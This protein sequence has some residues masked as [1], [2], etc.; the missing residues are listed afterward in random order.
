MGEPN[1]SGTGGEYAGQF[2]G[3]QALWNDLGGSTAYAADMSSVYNVMGYVRETNL[4]DSPLTIDAGGGAVSFGADVGTSKAL[5]NLTLSNVGVFSANGSVNLGGNLGLSAQSGINP[6]IGQSAAWVIGGTSSFNVGTGN[7]TLDRSDNDFTGAVSITSAADVSL[8]DTT[9][10]E[11]GSV[12]LSGAFTAESSEL[13]LTGDLTSSGTGDIFIKSNSAT[14]GSIV[15]NGDVFKTGGDRSTLT[16]QADGR[17]NINGD[18]TATVTSLDT[19]LWSDFH[20]TGSGG[21]SNFG[22]VTTNGGHVWAGGSASDGGSST[23]N[24][25]TVGD[26]ASEGADGFNYNALDLYGSLSTGGGDVMLRAGDGYNSGIDG[27][28]I[29]GA[30]TINSVTGDITILANDVDG[31]TIE[32]TSTGALTFAPHDNAFTEIGTSINWAGATATGTFTGTGD[33]GWLIINNVTALGGLTIGKEGMTSSIDIDSAIE[34]AGPINLLGND[35]TINASLDTTGGGAA[36]DILLKAKDQVVV[37]ANQSITT[38]D[39]D[40]TFWSDSDANGH[41]NIR[42]HDGVTLNTA[43]GST[44][45][46]SGGGSIVIGGGLDSNSDDRPDGFATSATD[47]GV[48]FGTST[49]NIT[50]IHS[51]GGDV[52]IKGQST[53]TAAAQV[54]GFVSTGSLTVNSGGGSIAITGETLSI[55]NGLQFGFQ[56]GS[57][58]GA[59]LSSSASSGTAISISGKT[60][61]SSSNGVSIGGGDSNLIEATGGGDIIISA[62]GAGN[63]SGIALNDVDIL[64]SSG[65]IQLDAGTGRIALTDTTLG[66]KAGSSVTA[67]SSDVVFTSDRIKFNTGTAVATTGSLTVQPFSTSFGTTLDWQP[68]N[69]GTTLGSLTIGKVGNTTAIEID[70]DITTIGA[71]HFYG[72]TLLSSN[73]DLNTTNSAVNFYGTVDS[74]STVR[75]LS[76]DTG[77]AATTFEST[78][79]GTEAL[80]NLN[81]T[82]LSNVNAD[83]TTTVEQSY[84]GELTIGGSGVRTLNAGTLTTN[85]IVASSNDFVLKADNFAIGGDVTGTGNATLN[86]S[87]VGAD[88]GVGTATDTVEVDNA[89]LLAFQDGFASITVGETD[90]GSLSVSG[91]TTMNDD[92]TLRAGA[93]EDLS[94]SGA[95]T[96]VGNN[97]LTL[98][99]GNDIFVNDDIDVLGSGAALNLFY[100]GTDGTAEATSGTDFYIDVSAKRQIT[101]ADTAAAL[102]IGNEAF[103]LVDSVAS[104][105][106]MSSSGNYALADD[107][108]L[109]GTTYT[110]AFY[111]DTFAGKLDGLGHAANGLKVTAG[112]GGNYGLFDQLSAASVRHFGVTNIDLLGQSSAAGAADDLRIGG[113]VGNVSGSG[114]TRLDG[115]WSSGVIATKQ[116]SVQ[117]VFYA[118]GLVGGH[119]SGTLEVTRSFSTANVSSEGSNS[120]KMS[121]GGLLGDSGSFNGISAIG[122]SASHLLIDR[123]Y[124]TGSI[125]EG[126]YDGY[127][128]SGGLVGVVFG[129]S[130]TLTDSFSRSNVVGGV[131][132][133][134]IAGFSSGTTTKNYDR[135]YTTLDRFGNN[136]TPRNSYTIDTLDAATS[137]GTVLPSTWSSSIWTTGKFPTLNSVQTPATLLYVKIIFGTGVYGNSVAPTY[138][139][140]D[141]SDAEVNFGNGAYSDLDGVTGT[142]RY[143]VGSDSSAGT[144]DRVSYLSG[145]GLTGD[146][147]DLYALNPHTTAGSY[148]ITPRPLTVTLSNSGVTKIYD[149]TTVAPSGFTPAFSLGNL[150]SGDAAAAINYVSAL[151]NDADVADASKLTVGGLS[152][153]SITGSNGSLVTDYS[154]SSSVDVAASITP[155]PIVVSG[156]LGEDKIYDGTTTASIDISSMSLSGIISGDD[157]SVTSITALFGNKNVGTDK[158]VTLSA[159]VFGGTDSGNYSI[160]PQSSATADINVKSITVQGITTADKVYDGTI[161]AVDDVSGLTFNGIVSGDNLT[162]ADTTGVFSSRNVDSDKTVILSDTSYGG[163]DVG[164]YNITDQATSVADVTKKSIT[165]SGVTAA[166]KVY[167]GSASAVVDLSGVTFDGIV[168]GDNL[169][170]ADTTG[171]FDKKNGGADKAV[172]LSGTNYSGSDVGNYSF[173]DQSLTTADVTQKSITV[174]GIAA[175]NKVYD[176]GTTTFVDLS[177]ITFAGIVS[178]DDLTATDGL[179]TFDNK[180]VGANKAITLSGTNYGGTDVGNYL[181]NDQTASTASITP[182]QV[183]VSGL[184]AEDRSY[185]GN[186]TSTIGHDGLNVAGLVVGDDVTTSGTTGSIVDKNVGTGK[187]VNLTGT[188]YGG[189]D[190]ANYNFLDQLVAFAEISRLSS[191]TWVGGPT[192][193][194][195]D[196]ANWAG[197]AVPDLANVADV[198]IPDGVTPVFDDSVSGPV[199]IESLTGGSLQLDAGDLHVNQDAALDQFTQNGGTMGVEGNFEVADF[200]QNAGSL[201]V[202]GELDVTNSFSQSETATTDVEGDVQ[203]TQTT[204]DLVI[205]NLSGDNVDLNSPS[206]GIELGN[207]ETAGTLNATAGDGSITQTPGSQITV[208]GETTLD[209]TEDIL[210]AEAGNDFDGPVNASGENVEITDGNGG[211]VLGQIT[212]TGSFTG[213]STGGP[214]TQTED[215]SL[216]IAGT[217]T[218]TASENGSPSDIILDGDS[219]DFGGTVNADGGSIQLVD[220]SGGLELGTVKASG[221]LNVVSTDGPLTQTESGSIDVEGSSSFGAFVDG[222]PDQVILDN[223]DNRFGDSVDVVGGAIQIQGQ[224]QS[225]GAINFGTVSSPALKSQHQGATADTTLDTNTRYIDETQDNLTIQNVVQRLGITWIRRLVDWYSGEPEVAD[226]VRQQDLVINN[227]DVF[228]RKSPGSELTRLKER[229]LQ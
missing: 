85:D 131:S 201:E 150:I 105:R 216:A 66:Q 200:E 149:N 103:T 215:S 62:T 118:G 204:G 124:A 205:N 188:V 222:E 97:A 68:I 64:A 9:S 145:L 20:D 37:A 104:L 206:G 55:T 120:S 30:Q 141:R 164:N 162:A 212:A 93:G 67:S 40:I 218:L 142:G 159:P 136:H 225:G 197:G 65:D 91:L 50:T 98:A 140:V 168:S 135:L 183:T 160:T 80:R 33:A 89:T 84:G 2:F 1:G 49:A 185:N 31:G 176:G 134:G 83:V 224:S 139:I 126:T 16:V 187:Q 189:A 198:V 186:Q 193:D 32:V 100:G 151:F 167:D 90:S 174:S 113:I 108:S 226:L 166:D 46:A 128:G 94:V 42:I 129:T 196:P 180:N 63:N 79:G 92:F 199:E 86:S 163:T 43:D 14:D 229:D 143:T 27:I 148:T 95:I 109:A 81:V 112:T 82:G 178:G 211:L 170:A 69:I 221:D 132:S 78:V 115:V 121:V 223:P 39:A 13:T 202:L 114:T 228:I 102:K 146:D 8:K 169:T 122:G 116:G 130:A 73:I 88:L 77:T 21:V 152:I 173:T 19:V 44:S 155:K 15:I 74:S 179:G 203:I 45:Q 99:A 7:I 137:N 147:A 5:G 192:G 165:I 184:A 59:R 26:G 10:L 29:N 72:P 138:Q 101:F 28:G 54:R 181:I 11:L 217:T 111:N 194:W 23:W 153:A 123:S 61:N 53:R 12:T 76:I 18:I 56:A 87:T 209:A 190:A 171:E 154:I 25:L 71:Q 213:T 51:G 158:V 119:D 214:I 177:G 17:V 34:I 36:A 24:G 47:D 6:T 220:S 96:W 219:N 117:D 38:D 110:E 52:V 107:L 191:V 133:G 144:Y 125:V 106:G 35:V 175:S 4:A 60:A 161:S 41:G 70:D 208:G 195:S 157:V 207:V 57:G 75:N 58:S 48:E 210:L 172:T 3:N 227:G 127:Y 156:I 182:K 22:T